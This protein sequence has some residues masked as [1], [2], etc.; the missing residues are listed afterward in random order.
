MKCRGIKFV[1]KTYFFPLLN[2]Q[3][4]PV[5]SRNNWT[6][7]IDRSI[8]DNVRDCARKA[9]GLNFQ[10]LPKCSQYTPR[11]YSCNINES[12]LGTYLAATWLA[13]RNRCK[14]NYSRVITDLTDADIIRRSRIFRIRRPV[15]ISP[16]LSRK[17]VLWTFL[18]F[19][20]FCNLNKNGNTPKCNNTIFSLS[21]Q[22][23]SKI[24][25]YIYN[26]LRNLINFFL[27]TRV[28]TSMIFGLDDKTRD[29]RGWH[30]VTE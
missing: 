26:V 1:R 2:I 22:F 21:I 23:V 13:V 19:F 8:S 4:K 9:S 20:F 17:F 11:K 25:I 27:R 6:K 10:M 16:R 5:R 7:E 14:A 3:S 18:F 28:F 12:T 30:A 15:D 29:W 24:Y